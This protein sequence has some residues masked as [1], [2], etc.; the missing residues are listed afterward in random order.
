[1]T[2]A[3]V[4]DARV[5]KGSCHCGDMRFEVAAEIAGPVIECN[6][7]HCRRK[8]YLLWFVPRDALRH[9]I[10]EHHMATYTFNAHVIQHHFCLRCGCAPFA[11]GKDPEGNTTAAI[12]VRCLEDVDPASLERMQV[13][14]LSR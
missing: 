2:A 3:T 12:N 7:S 5:H 14:G 4:H 13:D 1:M 11:E 9:A 6:C 10:P 8:G